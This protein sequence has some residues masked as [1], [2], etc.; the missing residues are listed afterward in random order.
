MQGGKIKLRKALV[1]GIDD[2]PNYPL[3]GCVNDANCIKNTIETNG[4]GSRNFSVK[5]ATNTQE[6]P[7]KATLLEMIKE[8][9]TGECECALLYFSGHGY[10]NEQGGYIV[11][12]DF[13]KDNNGISMLEIL[14][15]A[16]NSKIQNKVIILD[17]C[18]SGNM[19]N[20]NDGKREVCH[21]TDGMSILTASR[22]DETAKEICGHGV[23]T[24]LL[25]EA[26]KGGASSI[27]GDITVGS[28]YS[29]IDQALGPW[30]QRPVFKTN[31]TQFSSLRKINP[32]IPLESLRKLIEYFEQPENEFELDPSFEY[33][34]S[35][36]IE[37]EVVEPFAK[38][39]N[40]VKFKTLQKLERVGLVVPVGEEH[41]YWAAMNS[42]SCK[43][44]ALGY[45]YWKLIK[46]QNI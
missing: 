2:Y 31:V 29:Y 35:K 21:I 6:V 39:E 7:D 40:I 38:E 25:I 10:L 33:T 5:L 13:N 43:L 12:P 23:F 14:N 22:K 19:G 27:T 37:H 45:H 34:N 18:Y 3:K 16:N 30:D 17:S 4:D 36:S 41:M 32:I 9:F 26:L 28:I 1:V 44:T 46:D 20:I 42:K 11:T 15:L 24:S 8:V